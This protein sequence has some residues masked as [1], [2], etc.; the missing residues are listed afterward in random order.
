MN[1][2]NTQ[3]LI[4]YL[5]QYGISNTMIAIIAKQHISNEDLQIMDRDD[6]E[7]LFKNEYGFTFRDRKQF[8]NILQK[9]QSNSKSNIK[10]VQ[11]DNSPEILEHIYEF[12]E[13]ESSENNDSIQQQSIISSSSNTNQQLIINHLFENKTSDD[14]NNSNSSSY[15]S[16]LSLSSDYVFT[17]PCIL[18]SFSSNI[19][20]A[21]KTNTIHKQWAAFINELARW[22]MSIKPCL[23]EQH[24]YRAIG[25]SLFE[26][27]P[28]I[29]TAGPKPWSFLC[30]SLSQRIR[31]ERWHRRKILTTKKRKENEMKIIDQNYDNTGREI[32]L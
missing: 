19:I 6:V 15:I 4:T 7:H 24:E 25:Q 1:N 20:Q 17:Y 12:A 3:Q 2:H 13:E 16:E 14:D 28:N 9:I 22:V 26:K 8:W 11:I 32:V 10:N 31:T 27:Y 5:L 30:R 18:P 21:L 29:G 23:R